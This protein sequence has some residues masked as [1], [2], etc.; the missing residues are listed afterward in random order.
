MIRNGGLT[1]EKAF[2]GTSRAHYYLTPSEFYQKE[3]GG[4][5]D[6]ADTVKKGELGVL[7]QAGNVR[8]I[9]THM[10]HY[11]ALLNTDH[12]STM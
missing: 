3:I 10:T 11:D 4:K 5:A 8:Y 12:F 7:D 6:P 2:Y 1:R 9:Y